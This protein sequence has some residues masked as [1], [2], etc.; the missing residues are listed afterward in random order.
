MEFFL[1]DEGPSLE[2]LENYSLHFGITQ[3]FPII[4]MLR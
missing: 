4:S 1:S 3:T 2:T